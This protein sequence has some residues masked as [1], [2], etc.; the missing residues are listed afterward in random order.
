MR[1]RLLGAIALGAVTV[2]LVTVGAPGSAP[3]PRGTSAVADIGSV[4]Y[5]QPIGA[6]HEAGVLPLPSAVEAFWPRS[7]AFR[8]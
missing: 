4:S 6:S 5:G 2:D 7:L 1:G 3:N 8:S